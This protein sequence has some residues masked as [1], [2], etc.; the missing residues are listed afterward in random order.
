MLSEN[1]ML[2][3]ILN[4]ARL[5]DR[6]RLVLMNGSRV[7]PDATHDQFSDFDIVFY[8]RD[9]KSFIRDESWIETHFGTILILQKPDD[10][11]NH[12]YDYENNQPFTYLVQL[13]D[14]NRIDLT[15]VD[16]E[17]IEDY[18]NKT[19]GDPGRI[20]LQKDAIKGVTNYDDFDKFVVRLPSIKEFTD[21]CNEFYWLA[22]YISKGI[23]RQEL[24]YV[25]TIM[26]TV[27]FEQL[28]KMLNWSVTTSSKSPVR[29]GHFSKYLQRYL[30]SKDYERLINCYS[31]ADFEDI[32]EKEINA[33]K[34]FHLHAQIVS[35]FMDF[36]YDN[37]LESNMIHFLE[38]RKNG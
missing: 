29:T 9:I 28:Y 1:E 22:P 17:N 2:D 14:G 4:F 26:E 36:P 24:I 21:T 19:S 8:V 32:W 25:K 3:L 30:K 23:Y 11:F 12:P 6:I 33:I 16:I 5:D 20:L 37:E 35:R 15:L 10:W 31:G 7:D 18:A 27:Q 38:S 34:L 13:L